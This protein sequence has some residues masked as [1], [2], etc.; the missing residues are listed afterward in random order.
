MECVLAFHDEEVIVSV[1]D[2][3]NLKLTSTNRAF[4]FDLNKEWELFTQFP[5]S[6]QEQS[7]LVWQQQVQRA[8]IKTRIATVAG[9]AQLFQRTP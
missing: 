7:A 3:V 6:Y 5:G 9:S 8:G 4:Y 1:R 2:E